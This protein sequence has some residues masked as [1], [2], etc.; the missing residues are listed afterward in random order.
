MAVIG[1]GILGSCIAMFV[2]LM[3]ASKKVVLLERSSIGSGATGM[4]AG[5]IWSAGFSK[6]GINTLS[7]M[8][9]KKLSSS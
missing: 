5:T 3:D 8:T 1:G 2:K 6:S 9:A 4:S 7:N